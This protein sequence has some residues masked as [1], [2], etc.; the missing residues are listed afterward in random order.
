ME[1]KVFVLNL[2]ILNFFVTDLAQ[3]SN[4]E[5]N[6]TVTQQLSQYHE[7]PTWF[8]YNTSTENCECYHIPS[9]EQIVKCT[10]Q[11][12]LLQ[13]GYC[14]TYEEGKGTFVSRC[15]YFKLEGHNV[16]ESFPGFITLP[17]NVSELNDYMCGP[18]NR[19]GLLCGECEEGFGLSFLSVRPTCSKCS[20]SE[21][22]GGVILYFLLGV[23]PITLVYFFFLVVFNI[24]LTSAPF[25]AFVLFSQIAFSFLTLSNIDLDFVLQNTHPIAT[26]YIKILI[27]FYGFWDLDF[28]LV[29]LI[30]PF[31]LSKNLTVHSIL[32]IRHSTILMIPAI[33]IS[34][35]W[36]CAK[37]YSKNFKPCVYTWRKIHPLFRKMKRDSK[38]TFVEV[39]CTFYLLFVLKSVEILIS[40]PYQH[41]TLYNMNNYPNVEVF[42][43]DPRR[44]WLGPYYLLIVISIYF[45]FVFLPLVTLLLLY[46]V[47]VCRLVC[48]K[49]ECPA[50]GCGHAR[51]LLN[52]IAD[53][54][55]ECYRDGLDGSWDMRYFASLYFIVKLIFVC[56]SFVVL[57]PPALYYSKSV[58]Y[59]SALHSMS[60]AYT[61]LI[62]GT[63]TIIAITQPYKK[64]YMN[65]ID[66][67]LF[68]DLALIF[69]LVGIWKSPFA[70]EAA[71]IAGSIPMW[72]LLGFGLYKV[73]PFRRLY[74]LLKK[75]LPSYQRLYLLCCKNSDNNRDESTE[76]RNEYHISDQE[77]PDRVLNPEVYYKMK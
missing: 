49:F 68:V 47:R 64:K 27:T 8:F 62:G 33:L 39:Y 58:E 16:S 30:P 13:N 63:A 20:D 70:L 51:A 53:K 21:I 40:L 73:I 57:Q 77:L 12:A 29:Y 7:C 55:Y 18:W 65:S 36:L 35:T 59:Y 3:G 44:K 11:G 2:L 50:A 1:Y 69:V 25:T 71:V 10:E 4:N 22:A 24:D 67:L 72:G 52:I 38:N 5:Y 28:F 9:T 48:F 31:C 43:S 32:I 17:D 6:S 19:K 15:N 76:L 74:T 41:T 26:S 23:V 61:L 45:F 56:V 14:M 42:L 46:P 34:I 37:F 75:K 60:S 54:F 66:T